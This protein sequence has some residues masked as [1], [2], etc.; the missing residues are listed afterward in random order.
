VASAAALMDDGHMLRKACVTFVLA[1]GLLAPASASAAVTIWA[2]DGTKIERFSSASPGQV[3]G[4]KTVIGL[5]GGETLLGIDVRPATGQLM[6]LGSTGALYQLNTA[7]GVATKVGDGQSLAGFGTDFGVDFNPMVDRLRV[8][9]DE[10][11]NFRL[12]PLNGT[13]A[14]NDTALN[15]AGSVVSVA[16]DR[17]TP[18]GPAT[19]LFGIDS[20]SGRLVRIGGVDGTSPSPNSGAVADIGSLGVPT[21][22]SPGFDV[23]PDGTAY[24][25]FAN[26]SSSALYTVALDSGAA[27][28]VADIGGG[29]VIDIA[30]AQPQLTV[31]TAYPNGALPMLLRSRSDQPGFSGN[32]V[33]VT[34]LTPGERVVALDQR[35]STGGLYALTDADRLFQVDPVTGEAA[36]VGAALTPAL[37]TLNVGADFDPVSDSLRIVTDSEKNLRLDPATAALTAGPDLTPPGETTGAAYSNNVPGAT[38]TTLFAVDS[39]ANELRRVDPATGALT[40][41]GPLATG[42]VAPVVDITA[43]NGF[44]IAPSGGFGFLT[45]RDGASAVNQYRVNLADGPVPGARVV[46]VGGTGPGAEPGGMTVLSPGTFGTGPASGTE[47]SGVARVVV[48]RQV[49]TEGVATV[50]YATADG[51]AK[52]GEDYSAVN[53]VLTFA[54][55]ESAKVVEVPV[56][57]DTAVE[58]D[59]TFTLTLSEPG[60]GATLGNAPASTVTIGSDDVAPNPGPG[61][62][63][64]D[65]TKP[66]AFVTIPA[67]QTFRTLRARGLKLQVVAGEPATAK[68]TATIDSATRKRLKLRSRT[69]GTMRLTFKRGAVKTARLKL[70]SKAKKGVRRAKRAFRVTVGAVVTDTAKNVSRAK[71]SAVV[72]RKK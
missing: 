34:G 52:A 13:V 50:E 23:S 35:P 38:T 68:L 6:A 28:K 21:G 44:D 25:S 48:V 3:A 10:E 29:A 1:L 57:N 32:F 66:L 65:R 63:P 40:V 72:S 54:P 4:A 61:P 56:A 14:G 16:Y 41:V 2:T 62:T 39:A 36:Q 70:S 64:P 26:G 67:G 45:S 27:T 15:P 55:G 47:S 5:A 17:N 51:S 43:S 37:G 30:V 24:A 59:E 8:V 33:S 11:K 19:T 18:A 42:P 9:S 71:A 7:S 46:L 69:I 60:E 53:G 20:A 12:N 22:S 58:P 49:G 31:L